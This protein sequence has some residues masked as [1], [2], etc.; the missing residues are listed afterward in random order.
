MHVCFFLM[1]FPILVLLLYLQSAV[2]L[3]P[4][5]QHTHSQ[6]L[7]AFTGS[8]LHLKEERIQHFIPLVEDSSH[9]NRLTG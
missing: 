2:S 1:I 5:A 6:C 8:P 3:Y 4:S 7:L 9:F